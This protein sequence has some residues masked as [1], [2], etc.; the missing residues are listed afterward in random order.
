MLSTVPQQPQYHP[1]IVFNSVTKRYGNIVALSDC[2]F[3]VPHQ[4]IVGLVG[5]NGAGKTTIMRLISGEIKPDYGQI[6]VFGMNPL[7]NPAVASLLGVINDVDFFY[8]QMS[9]RNLGMTLLKTR[10][11]REQALTRLQEVMYEM[12]IADFLDWTLGKYSKGM[13]QRFKLGLA[14]AHDPD[15]IIA[16]EPF[17]GLDPLAR[18]F[19]YSK[20]KELRDQGK[21]LVLSSHILWELEKLI[22]HMTLIYLGRIVAEGKPTDIR[23]RLQEHPHQVLVETPDATKLAHLLVDLMPIPV[24]S[25]SRGFDSRTGTPTLTIFTTD[26]KQ[27][28]EFLV[29]VVVEENIV[30]TRLLNLDDNLQRVFDLLT[31]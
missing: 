25:V 20:F 8:P 3:I 5:P 23:I 30:I 19:M 18:E 4:R 1:L 12:G 24:K 28:Y 26:P 13:R 16:D 10:F 17:N 11:P 22:D 7:N 14:L 6:T 21:T 27:L 9:A 29:S 31:K 2:N 15:L